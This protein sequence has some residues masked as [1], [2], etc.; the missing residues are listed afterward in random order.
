MKIQLIAL[1]ALLSTLSAPAFAF[2]ADQLAKVMA[3]ANVQEALEK[4][5]I[6]SVKQG[7]SYR[8]MGC[9]GLV[10]KTNGYEENAGATYNVQVMDFA[11][12]FHVSIAKIK[13]GS[14]QE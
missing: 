4:Q 12:R 2:S 9:Y 11:G 13:T 6:E 14:D 1:T 8:C 7:P 3:Q 10:I 5:N